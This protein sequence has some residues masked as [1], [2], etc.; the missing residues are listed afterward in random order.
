MSENVPAGDDARGRPREFY[1]AGAVVAISAFIVLL[2]TMLIVIGLGGEKPDTNSIALL[3]S[4]IATPVVAIASAYFGIQVAGKAAT[5]AGAAA[6]NASAVAAQ[7]SASAR[8]AAVAAE[9]TQ[10]VAA[11]ALKQFT[12][13]AST[14]SRLDMHLSDGSH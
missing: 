11:E 7:A 2:L 9:G 13:V 4:A 1:V 14:L 3:I 10:H 6:G 5:E 8:A 12:D